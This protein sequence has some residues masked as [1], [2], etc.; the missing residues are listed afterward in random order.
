MF[1]WWTHH[2]L[3]TQAQGKYCDSDAEELKVKRLTVF[4]WC[5]CLE[6]YG[7]WYC[8]NW[9]MVMI[10]ILQ[11]A[12]FLHGVEVTLW[13]LY[14]YDDSYCCP[15]VQIYYEVGTC[16]VQLT[17]IQVVP[18]HTELTGL[19]PRVFIGLWVGMSPAAP[20]LMVSTAKDMDHPSGLLRRNCMSRLIF[21]K[22]RKQPSPDLVWLWETL[23]EGDT[24]SSYWGNV[25]TG[26][27]LSALG[28]NRITFGSMLRCIR[29][30]E[31]RYQE[32]APTLSNHSKEDFKAIY[33]AQN[34][35]LS[36]VSRFAV[37][38]DNRNPEEVARFIKCM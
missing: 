18:S 9:R 37:A 13:P 17:S 31:K 32:S 20:H 28:E 8:T 24:P 34:G 16:N 30:I 4:R 1:D 38:V 36:R 26:A 22:R 19:W 25:V 6:C 15:L 14:W 12:R 33:D 3:A 21:C 5:G 11:W 35:T 7:C 29:I 10:T 27:Q 2:T 23:Q